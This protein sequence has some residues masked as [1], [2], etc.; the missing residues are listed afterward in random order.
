MKEAIE[1]KLAQTV[2]EA[3]QFLQEDNMAGA[4]EYLKGHKEE[5]SEF[6]MQ[7][8]EGYGKNDHT[9]VYRL[10]RLIKELL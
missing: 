10:A 8:Y 7:V 4:I 3:A 5:I 6:C 1:K 9:G 2:E